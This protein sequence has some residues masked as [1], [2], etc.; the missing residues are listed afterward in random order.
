MRKILY[1]S[2]LPIIALAD[3]A[4]LMAKY[5]APDPE[6][7]TMKQVE[8]WIGQK[9]SDPTDA[10]A[11]KECMIARAADNPNQVSVAGK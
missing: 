10:A 8:R 1:I 3:C 4:N 7:K 5:E 11:L 2:L 9:V 6:S